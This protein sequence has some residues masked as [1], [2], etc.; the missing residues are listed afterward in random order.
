VSELAADGTPVAVTCRVLKI[1]R[2]PYY[3][4][5]EAPVSEA[6]WLQAH[7]MNALINAHRDDPQFGYRFLAA[8][9]A[10]S[11]WRM[12][13]RTAWALCAQQGIVS[14]S[15]RRHGKNMRP[16]PPVFDDLVRRV[17][18]AH[19]PN[20]VWLTDITEHPTSEG[21]STAVPSR[22]STPDGSSVT[23]SASG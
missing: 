3:R 2:Q 5:R 7:R 20:Q 4:W 6:E 15:Q 19:A 8:E 11:G 13:R 12:S 1:A 14:R 17:F 22:M 18:R 16:G 23:P 21:R 10:R 9:A